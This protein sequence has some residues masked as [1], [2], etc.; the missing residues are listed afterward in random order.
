MSLLVDDVDR[1]VV[2]RF[3]QDIKIRPTWMDLHPPRVVS[4]VWSIKTAH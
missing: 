4:R 3:H 2:S 1:K